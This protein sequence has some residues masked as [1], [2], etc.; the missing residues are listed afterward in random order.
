MLFRST[1]YY[2]ANTKAYE[3]PEYVEYLESHPNAK[4]A[5]DQLE[6]SELS[7]LT[8]SLFTGVSTELR[9]IWQEEMDLYLQDAYSIDEALTEMANRS[10]AAITS[11]NS[12]AA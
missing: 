7:T 10:N 3:V 12:T 9:Q 8:G 1:G 4:V 11:Y 2:A 6:S 5:L